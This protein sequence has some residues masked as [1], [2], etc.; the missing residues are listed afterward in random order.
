M[1]ND[2]DRPDGVEHPVGTVPWS[3]AVKCFVGKRCYAQY[4]NDDDELFFLATVKGV[5]HQHGR[6]LVHV[7]YDDGEQEEYKP[8]SR[9]HAL[10]QGTGAA[11]PAVA[12]EH[13]HAICGNTMC[14]LMPREHAR[15]S[16]PP[17]QSG[18]HQVEYV[19]VSCSEG[20]QRLQ[21][22][23]RVS[24]WW[25]GD[26]TWYKGIA[27]QIRHSERGVR[28]SIKYEDGL[29]K[30]HY[31]DDEGEHWRLLEPPE[32]EMGASDA[33]DPAEEFDCEGH[34]SWQGTELAMVCPSL[35]PL[36]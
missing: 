11:P 2:D 31:L 15:F 27:G 20:A 32:W 33:G 23:D 25:D 26:G 7:A 19:R 36:P 9:V 3:D 13:S 17:V 29:N 24:V 30:W 1:G 10:C 6:L 21:R 22:G 4:G 16:T 35:R 5:V 14:Y 8:L 18:D 28:V 34:Q 12:E